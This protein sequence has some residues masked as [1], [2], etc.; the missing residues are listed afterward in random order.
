[1]NLHFLS[2]TEDNNATCIIVEISGHRILVDCGSPEEK[3]A[4]GKLIATTEVHNTPPNTLD[5]NFPTSTR[6][7]SPYAGLALQE[8]AQYIDAI[9]LSHAH[10]EQISG[11]PTLHAQIPDVPIYTT[12]ATRSILGAWLL[13]YPTETDTSAKSHLKAIDRRSVE[14]MIGA[15]QPVA[16][17]E[18]REILDGKVRIAFYPA[19]HILGAAAIWIEDDY[20]SVLI[21]G[22]FTITEQKTISGMFLP[23]SNPDLLV[24]DSSYGDR[25]HASRTG[26]EHRLTQQITEVIERGG[27]ILFP[28]VAIGRSQELI[29]IAMQAIEKKKIPYVPILVD[30]MAADI[31]D[32]YVDYPELMT[33][34]LR[35]RT[36]TMGHPFYYVGSP[37]FPVRTAEAREAA[38]HMTPSIIIAGCHSLHSGSA[39]LYA[40]ILAANPQSFIAVSGYRDEDIP[41]I[42]LLQTAIV[43]T[44]TLNIADEQIPLHCGIGT[45]GLGQHA[46]MTQ[47]L[48]A[49]SSISPRKIAL[50]NGHSRARDMLSNSLIQFDI[51]EVYLPSDGE[52]LEC[53][54]H[55]GG[56]SQLK[57]PVRSFAINA[58][59]RPL[60]FDDL[61]QVA[62]ILR[63]RDMP[64]KLYSIQDILLAWCGEEYNYNEQ[65]IERISRFIGAKASPF[66]RDKKRAY[67]YR[68]RSDTAG[69]AETHKVSKK[70]VT[71]TGE[72]PFD[73][74]RVLQHIDKHL[75]ETHGLYKRSIIKDKQEVMLSFYF[76]KIAIREYSDLIA[77]LSQETGWQIEIRPHPNQEKMISIISDVLPAEYVMSRRPSIYLLDE[78]IVAHLNQ[79]PSSELIASCAEIYYNKTGF[80]LEFQLA[81]Q[82]AKASTQGDET[83]ISNDALVSEDTSNTVPLHPNNVPSHSELAVGEG[84]PDPLQS[85]QHAL[86]TAADLCGQTKAQN[87][88][89]QLHDAPPVAPPAQN[90]HHIIP[91]VVLLAPDNSTP[92]PQTQAN[93]KTDHKNTDESDSSPTANVNRN[94]KAKSSK[95][96]HT[97]HR[98]PRSESSTP[99]PELVVYK[100]PTHSKKQDIHEGTNAAPASQSSLYAQIF[101]PSSVRC[102]IN[103]AYNTIRQAFANNLHPLLK[104]SL[105]GNVLEVTFIS[106]QVG[107][108]YT[109]LLAAISAHLGYPIQI[110]QQADQHRI[111]EQAKQ[112]ISAHTQLLK[113]PSFFQNN[114]SVVVEVKDMPSTS[115]CEDLNRS[116]LELTGFQLIIKSSE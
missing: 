101:P 94:T 113:E 103:R 84:E 34:W 33:P 81:E 39:P 77:M 24:V 25:L 15:C 43:G 11:L 16:F 23:P 50:I 5:N 22:H 95:R 107:E 44:G 112:L 111:K 109:D 104:T 18:Y 114:S 35:N 59:R 26:E 6:D 105:R 58:K 42:S 115:V 14:M 30:G 99:M 13:A 68:L 2:G 31:C 73:P 76:P 27:S 53:A 40:K 7:I 1:M 47:L 60:L 10:I 87:D 52:I 85:T 48:S 75:D 38:L 71:K 83:P 91:A 12:S 46:D 110:R 36:K 78:R 41:D 65:E 32:I 17:G 70:K 69:A 82:A 29:L 106:P 56:H 98:Y 63:N 57:T 3:R 64:N 86:Y 21:T 116:F 45:Y 90:E 93:A 108:R 49:I 67:L 51:S 74:F 62:D 61:D 54:P 66:Q 72:G 37:V 28:A 4:Q 100:R 8:I 80:N 19:G 92:K 89:L 9:C 102:E 88:T 79:L 97:T 55:K 96:Q 20:N